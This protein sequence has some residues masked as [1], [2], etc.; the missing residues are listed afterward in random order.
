M[1]QRATEQRKE[2]A[3]TDSLFNA[4]VPITGYW[5]NMAKCGCKQV[6]WIE[7]Q[8]Q[9]AFWRRPWMATVMSRLSQKSSVKS[10]VSGRKPRQGQAFT[11]QT[12]SK[13]WSMPSGRPYLAKSKV[14]QSVGSQVPRQTEKRHYRSSNCSKVD[15]RNYWLE[16]TKG[17]Q[18][19]FNMPSLAVYTHVCIIYNHVPLQNIYIIS[20][21]IYTYHTCICIYIY[22]YI[23]REFSVNSSEHAVITD[24]LNLPRHQNTTNKSPQKRPIEDQPT[25]QTRKS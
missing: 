13:R 23:E 15:F 24:R 11:P 6:K 21:L 2:L 20:A 5:L 18:R 17:I 8:H 16:S 3:K 22:I 12:G 10:P 9:K 1:G 19:H 7:M 25:G 14:W 4:T